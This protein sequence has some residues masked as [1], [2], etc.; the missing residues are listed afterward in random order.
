MHLNVILLHCCTLAITEDARAHVEVSLNAFP[1]LLVFCEE[2]L[3]QSS[4]LGAQGKGTGVE[5][6]GEGV[7]REVIDHY[8]VMGGKRRC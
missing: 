2:F 8:G 6:G 5:L 3:N 7:C 1:R 4:Q